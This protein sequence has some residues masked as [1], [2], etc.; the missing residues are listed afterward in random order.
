MKIRKHFNTLFEIEDHELSRVFYIVIIQFFSGVALSMFFIAISAIFLHEVS[1]FNLYIVFI[2][3]SIFVMIANY[4]YTN[5]EHHFG[6]AKTYYITLIFSSLIL[7]SSYFVLHSHYDTLI[8]I[9]FASYYIIYFSNNMSFWGV[10]SQ[11]FNVR[12]SKRLFPLMSSGDLIS[13]LVGYALAGLLAGIVQLESLL[14]FSMLLF[15]CSNVFLHLMLKKNNDRIVVNQTHAPQHIAHIE[16]NIAKDEKKLISSICKLGFFCAMAVGFSEFFF[17]GEIKASNRYSEHLAQFLGAIFFV[18]RLV[19]L[20]FKLILSAKIEKKLGLQKILSILPAFIFISMVLFFFISPADHYLYALCVYVVLFEGIKLST[21]DP[22]YFAMIQVVNPEKRLKIHAKS[23]GLFA[24]LGQLFVGVSIFIYF[25]IPHEFIVKYLAS[26]LGVLS[27]FWIIYIVDANKKYYSYIHKLLVKYSLFNEKSS[28]IISNECIEKSIKEKIELLNE[29]DSFFSVQYLYQVNPEF[30]RQYFLKLLRKNT[31]KNIL[32][33]IMEKARENSWNEYV[34]QIK[35][36]FSESDRILQNSAVMLL[37]KFNK[38][39]FLNCLY[40]CRSTNRHDLLT[41]CIHGGVDNQDYSVVHICLNLIPQKLRSF[42]PEEKIEGLTLITKL[43]NR[44]LN[45]RIIASMTPL[46]G[47]KDPVIKR[48]LIKAIKSLKSPS[49][50]PYLFY[51]LRNNKYASDIRE[52]LANYSDYW[53]EKIHSIG[54]IHYSVLIHILTKSNSNKSRE[55]L[56]G[57]FYENNKL[58]EIIVPFL[59]KINFLSRDK[60][61]I[62]E[63]I[64]ARANKLNN[65]RE[66]INACRNTCLISALVNEKHKDLFLIIC[67]LHFLDPIPN[68]YDLLRIVQQKQTEY[69]L[70]LIEKIEFLLQKNRLNR[71]TSIFEKS[72]IINDNTIYPKE[73]DEVI[74]KKILSEKQYVY[75]PWIIA[76]AVYFYPNN[77]DLL[78][79]THYREET[80]VI[81]LLQKDASRMDVIS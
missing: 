25:V 39:E 77:K 65:L 12:E 78:N 20:L 46:L 41:S 34:S 36:F 56:I 8:V 79:A 44:A 51:E 10:A 50:L 6:V 11:I 35:P 28:Y 63:M 30:S 45:S 33:F 59:I 73:S 7:G 38:N 16:N 26:T 19:A 72:L 61:L 75:S 69:Y 17:L 5:I 22:F 47:T 58:H 3:A 68:I 9:V 76:V 14:F 64:I 40:Y 49:Y 60:K 27:L 62:H 74:V 71:I 55:Y 31:P 48:H 54:S 42:S 23:K 43:A 80:L 52:C 57:V 81:E 70:Y 13:K 21:Y 18:G 32:L 66:L 24:P 15:G 2:V 1:V 67:Y 53:L 29:K 4:F 37:S